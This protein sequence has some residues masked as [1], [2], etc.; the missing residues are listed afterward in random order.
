MLEK[1]IE[2]N[3][4]FLL[5]N[6]IGFFV[7]L[8]VSIFLVYKYKLLKA[9]T[10]EVLI[11]FFISIVVSIPLSEHRIEM[12]GNYEVESLYSKDYFSAIYLFWYGLYHKKYDFNIPLIYCGIFYSGV[13]LDLLFI[14]VIKKDTIFNEYIGGAGIYDGLFLYPIFLCAFIYLLK[15]VIYYQEKNKEIIYDK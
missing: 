6:E 3:L 12:I 13:I 7:P 1:V 9:L 5:G 8:L 10:P 2:Q 15:K 11:I 4:I 14:V